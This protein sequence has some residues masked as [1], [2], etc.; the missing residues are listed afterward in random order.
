MST[1]GNFSV[2][3]TSGADEDVFAFEPATLG[4]S[5]S[6]TFRPGLYFD[7][8]TY[9]FGNDVGG[10]QVA[11]PP[12]SGSGAAAAAAPG[13][14]GAA[15][16]GLMVIMAAPPEVPM[17]ILGPLTFDQWQ[18]FDSSDFVLASISEAPEMLDQ[19]NKADNKSDD[20]LYV[21]CLDQAFSEWGI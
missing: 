10:L 16:D 2:T 17:E 19:E 21:M 13:L 8:S 4:A 14:G 20:A 5:T 3:G 7:G 15:P 18:S 12:A 6:G 1:T 11:E 9:G